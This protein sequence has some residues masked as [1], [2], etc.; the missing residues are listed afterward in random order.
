MRHLCV[1]I[2]RRRIVATVLVISAGHWGI[3]IASP[4][5]SGVARRRRRVAVRVSSGRSL[6]A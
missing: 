2:L 5:G 4:A 1:G 3:V 6:A